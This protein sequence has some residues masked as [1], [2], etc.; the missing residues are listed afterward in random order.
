MSLTGQ[1][2]PPLACRFSERFYPPSDYMFLN[3]LQM[4]V[5]NVD[6]M[7]ENLM[8]C[9]LQQR[10][11]EWMSGSWLP[12]RGAACPGWHPVPSVPIQMP[13]PAGDRQP[14]ALRCCVGEPN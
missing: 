12:E 13:T 3:A 4:A 1:E 10:V 2:R 14:P 11:A 5:L 7:Q 6:V 8:K 9:E